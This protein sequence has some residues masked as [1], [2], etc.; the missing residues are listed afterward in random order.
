MAYSTIASLIDAVGGAEKYVQLTDKND[1]GV[2]DD[3]VGAAAIVAAD[4]LIDSY[5]QKR[6]ATPFAAASPVVVSLSTRLAAWELRRG[7]PG[8]TI[9]LD[10][11]ELHKLDMA[12]LVSLSKGEVTPGVEP[13]ANSSELL[14]DEAGERSSLKSM[15]RDKT[16]GFW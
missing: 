8:T 14:V 13:G 10:E 7:K 3:T 5:A 4:A 15:S 6:Y 2:A 16:R 9:T 11:I 1:I 12:W